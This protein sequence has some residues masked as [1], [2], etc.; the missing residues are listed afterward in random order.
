MCQFAG[1]Y[2]QSGC[3]VER[4][5]IHIYTSKYPVQNT[6]TPAPDGEVQSEYKITYKTHRNEVQSGS[7]YWNVMAVARSVRV[8]PGPVGVPSRPPRTVGLAH[9][10]RRKNH[11]RL[12]VQRAFSMHRP[13]LSFGVVL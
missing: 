12:S 8:G 11:G 4:G 1:K 10:E 5:N 6:R 9:D 3:I 2:Y 7:Y 13:T